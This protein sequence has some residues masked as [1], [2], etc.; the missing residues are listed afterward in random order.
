MNNFS[1]S[2]EGNLMGLCKHSLVNSYV[3]TQ[4]KTRVGN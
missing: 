3:P 2:E 1:D 4:I